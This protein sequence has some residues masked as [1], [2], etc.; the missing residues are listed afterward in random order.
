MDR[1]Q[2]M[3]QFGEVHSSE[4]W[5]EQRDPD[6]AANPDSWWFRMAGRGGAQ[7]P[8]WMQ[9]EWRMAHLDCPPGGDRHTEPLDDRA[10]RPLW[11]ERMNLSGS[12]GKQASTIY[13]HRREYTPTEKTDARSM[14][15]GRA[16]RQ[17]SALARGHGG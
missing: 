4:Q 3:E 12:Q 14:V 10:E 13:S 16:G 8:L 1:Q 7:Q 5:F 11:A 17:A 2:W 9:R 6:W 15:G